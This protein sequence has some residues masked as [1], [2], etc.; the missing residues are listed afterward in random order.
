ML[1][2][3]SDS[4]TSGAADLASL[5]VALTAAEPLELLAPLVQADGGQLL[6]A[7]REDVTYRPGRDATV[8]LAATVRRDGAEVREGWVLSAGGTPPS[9][10]H[11]L[12]GAA[13]QVAAWRVRDDPDLPGLRS[14]LDATAVAGLL[15]ALGLSPEGLSLQLVSVRPR[16]RAVVEI[17]TSSARLFLKCVPPATIDDLQ[18]RHRACRAAGVPVPKALGADRALGLLILSP[19]AGVPLRSMLLTDTPELPPAGQVADLLQAFAAVD[20]ALPARDPRRHA[21]GHAALLQSILPDELGRIDDQLARITSAGPGRAGGVHGDFYDAQLLVERGRIVGVVDVDGAGAGRPAD[22]AGALLAHL[23]VLRGLVGS[24]AA[25]HRWLPVVATVVGPLH[26]PD[27][28]ARSTAAVLL[29]LATWPH[30]R[31]EPD[32]PAQTRQLLDLVDRVLRDGV[33]AA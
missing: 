26:D 20:L 8:R 28:L 6:A 12:E 16:R 10:A 24:S 31:H 4:P 32:W 3:M 27:E 11:V 17:R 2:V 1:V 23:L 25:V 22:D 13:G 19:L 30:T 9:G 14:A 29:G 5:Y 15:T 21:R 7:A 33:A 18:A